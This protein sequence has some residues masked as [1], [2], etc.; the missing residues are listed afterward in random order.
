MIVMSGF[1]T[2][3]GQ[4]LVFGGTNSTGGVRGDTMVFDWPQ[5]GVQG[6]YSQTSIPLD[7]RM[8]L[9]VNNANGNATVVNRDM[10]IA[11]TGRDLSID[12]VYNSEDR[13]SGIVAG[14]SWEFANNPLFQ[15]S[16]PD[17]SIVIYG[18][19]ADELHFSFNGS[20][21][22]S[23]PGLNA[24]LTVTSGVY[25]LTYRHSSEVLTFALRTKVPALV[26]AV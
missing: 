22:T 2:N 18:T 16:L 13:N 3:Y 21:F 12:R 26:Y 5:L 24:D 19:G 6:F 20:V 14:N 1:A 7:D 4:V 10:H 25:S 23:P 11:G 9:L 17:G 8:T 15:S